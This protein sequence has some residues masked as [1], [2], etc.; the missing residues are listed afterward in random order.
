MSPEV[1]FFT[2]TRAGP[3][4]LGAVSGPCVLLL[5]AGEE[6]KA[7][8]RHLHSPRA[9]SWSGSLVGMQI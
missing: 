4:A 2:L 3:K 9:S 1:L 6:P 8:A 5:T 7:E